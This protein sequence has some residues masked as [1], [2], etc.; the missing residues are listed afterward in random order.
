V[1]LIDGFGQRWVA[2]TCVVR[3]ADPVKEEAAARLAETGIE[4]R[5]WWNRGCHR[6]ALFAELPRTELP[7]TEA[8]ADTTLGL[9]CYLDLPDSDIAVIC[10][11]VGRTLASVRA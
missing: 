1:T 7:V 3:F 11:E 5:S 10:A 6:E 2:A 4:T 9:P 8:L